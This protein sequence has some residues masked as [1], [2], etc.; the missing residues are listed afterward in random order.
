VIY[1]IDD[2]IIVNNSCFISHQVIQF[3]LMVFVSRYLPI[4][5][6]IVG[7]SALVFQTT[8]LYPWHNELDA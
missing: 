6:F 4:I 3:I 8:V 5:S 1:A 7:T 2:E